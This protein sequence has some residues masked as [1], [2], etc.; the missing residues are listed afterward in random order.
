MPAI[1]EL[2]GGRLVQ[3]VQVHLPVEEEQRDHA[4]V[5]Q[6]LALATC[7]RES[8]PRPLVEDDRLD[9]C[10]RRQAEEIAVGLHARPIRTASTPPKTTVWVRTEEAPTRIELVYTALQAAA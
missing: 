4:R 2:P 6:V 10:D 8:E 1:A 5:E 9:G 7:P 3:V